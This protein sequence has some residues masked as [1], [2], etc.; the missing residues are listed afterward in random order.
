M[1]LVAKVPCGKIN[2][3]NIRLWSYVPTRTQ[4][5]APQHRFSTYIFHHTESKDNHGINQFGLCWHDHFKF[6]NMSK[7]NVNHHKTPQMFQQ[8]CL[9]SR[10]TIEQKNVDMSTHGKNKNRDSH[11]CFLPSTKQEQPVNPNARS[12]SPVVKSDFSTFLLHILSFYCACKVC[13]MRNGMECNVWTAR[14]MDCWVGHAMCRVWSAF[15][16]MR[17]VECKM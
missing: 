8:T 16:G 7:D 14:K 1:R 4:C 5:M 2:W 17:S 15:C 9:V 13:W 6:K 3:T 11:T 10:K 12:A